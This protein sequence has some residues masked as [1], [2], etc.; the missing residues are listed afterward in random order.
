MVTLPERLVTA[1]SPERLTEVRDGSSVPWAGPEKYRASSVRVRVSIL[2]TVPSG[3]LAIQMMTKLLVS[4]VIMM[5]MVQ[6]LPLSL[7]DSFQRL[8]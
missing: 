1:T 5:S 3:E 2:E 7:L 4:W 8:D 6:R